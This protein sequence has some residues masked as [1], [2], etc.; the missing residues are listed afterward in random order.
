MPMRVTPTS[1]DFASRAESHT[2]STIA[3]TVRHAMRCKK[4]SVVLSVRTASHAI[5]S[6][7]LRVNPLLCR[8]HGTCETSTPCV[9]H[10]TRGASASMT[11]RRSP[12]SCVRQ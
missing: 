1:G 7:K 2:R 10:F 3:P 11:A 12:M 8:A 9:R 5:V 4:D 6:S